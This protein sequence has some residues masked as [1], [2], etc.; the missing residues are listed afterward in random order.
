MCP[1]I[2][3]FLLSTFY[4]IR[5]HAL[6]KRRQKEEGKASVTEMFNSVTAMV[7]LSNQS[8]LM[9]AREKG[10]KKEIKSSISV[11]ACTSIG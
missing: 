7:W 4:Q 5:E 8:L 11:Q 3:S 6:R 1:R 9:K 2:V 10:K